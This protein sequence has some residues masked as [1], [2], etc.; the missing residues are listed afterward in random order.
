MYVNTSADI[1]LVCLQIKIISHVSFRFTVRQLWRASCKSGKT[2]LC[3]WQIPFCV[4]LMFLLTTVISRWCFRMAKL[5]GSTRWKWQLA[6]PL[7][8]PLTKF[9]SS[10]RRL[11]TGCKEVW[12]LNDTPYY[13]FIS[14]LLFHHRDKLETDC[15]KLAARVRHRVKQFIIQHAFL[16]LFFSAL[17]ALLRYID[18][19]FCFMNPCQAL[20][21]RIMALQINYKE[22]KARRLVFYFVAFHPLPHVEFWNSTNMHYYALLIRFFL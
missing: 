5:L 1:H 22:E 9:E 10:W 11:M 17:C 4:P 3:C 13:V 12:A 2:F 8:S 20:P 6:S 21:N 14:L 18:Y 7:P 19:M 15:T 16:W